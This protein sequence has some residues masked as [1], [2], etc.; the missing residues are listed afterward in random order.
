MFNLPAGTYKLSI[1]ENGTL[2]AY[3]E[4]DYLVYYKNSNGVETWRE[5]DE[6][7]N[8]IHAKD[9]DGFEIWKEYD[10]NGNCIHSKNSEGLE[11]WREYDSNGNQ[12]YYKDFY[13]YEY[14][15]NSKGKNIT[16]EEFDRI[17]APCAG[18][19]I[20]VEGKKYRLT[21]L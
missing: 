17:Y 2:S 20:E 21:A 6:H 12:I 3:N 11:A 4:N 13:G 15:Y 14:W 5:Y 9:S 1:H 19:V 8:C 16:K 18:K 10:D 7:D